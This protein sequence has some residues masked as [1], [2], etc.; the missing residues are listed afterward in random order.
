MINMPS[1]TTFLRENFLEL[2]FSIE[3]NPK[4]KIYRL[5][6]DYKKDIFQNEEKPSYFVKY[7]GGIDGKLGIETK[8]MYASPPE[9]RKLSMLFYKKRGNVA[10]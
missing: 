7:F 4:V 6:G 3:K 9:I 5:K 1:R 8:R 10:F 2:N